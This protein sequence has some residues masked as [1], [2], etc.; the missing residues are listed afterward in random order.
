MFVLLARDPDAPDIVEA[1]ARDRASGIA[2]G[3]RPPSD[4]HMV[5]EAFECAA[6]MRRWREKN[7]SAKNGPTWRSKEK[8]ALPPEAATAEECEICGPDRTCGQ[9]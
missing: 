9:C 8:L 1:W 6:K 3:A 2:E 5:L 4:V 7:A